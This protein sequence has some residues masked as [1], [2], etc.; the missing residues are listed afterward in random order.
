[1]SAHAETRRG[2][3]VHAV[4]PDGVQTAMLDGQDPAGLGSQLVHSGGRILTPEEVAAAAVAL[5]GSR[6]VVQT[7]PSWRSAVMRA[8]ALAP[9]VSAQGVGLFAAMGRRALARR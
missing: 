8:S 7:L 5:I 9:G 2:V 6:R 4:C 3:R 1:M